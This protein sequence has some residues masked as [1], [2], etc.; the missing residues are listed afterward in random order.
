MEWAE[1]NGIE[2]KYQGPTEVDVAAQVQ[3]L[4][5]I[6]AQ[7]IDI[8]CFSPNDPDACENIVKQARDKGIIVIATEASGMEN[9]DYDVEAFSEEGRT[10]Q[11]DGRRRR[12]HHHGWVYDHGI[13]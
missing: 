5:D 11:D 6:I 3:I 2:V 1:E 8:L 9:I 10:G 12:I 7:D 4:T 13:P